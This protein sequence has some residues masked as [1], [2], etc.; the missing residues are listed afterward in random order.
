MLSMTK[1]YSCLIAV[2]DLGVLIANQSNI[3]K[4]PIP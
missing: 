2:I 3:S 1:L 4:S